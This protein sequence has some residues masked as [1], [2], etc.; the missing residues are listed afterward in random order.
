MT[1]CQCGAVS[2]VPGRCSVLR[3]AFATTSDIATTESAPG[4]SSVN[5]QQV[6]MRARRTAKRVPLKPLNCGWRP[7]ICKSCDSMLRSPTA[8]KTCRARQPA[9]INHCLPYNSRNVV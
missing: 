2:N 1:Q 6:C 5:K 4:L 9:L 3:L 8:L 7:V